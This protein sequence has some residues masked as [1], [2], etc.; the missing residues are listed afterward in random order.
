MTHLNDTREVTLGAPLTVGEDAREVALLNE[1]EGAR[2]PLPFTNGDRSSC[3]DGAEDENCRLTAEAAK[4]LCRNVT[5]VCLATRTVLLTASESWMLEP[6]D[7]M[8][9]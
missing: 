5:S 4:A 2:E 8:S 1:E 9:G 3:L 7:I 6:D